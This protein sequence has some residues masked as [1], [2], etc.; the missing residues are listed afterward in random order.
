MITDAAEDIGEP[1]AWIDIIQAGGDDQGTHRGGAVATTIR[2]GEQP[3]LS[4]DC[5]APKCAFRCIV[6]QADSAIAEESTETLPSLQHVV[7]RF[8]DIGVAREFGTCRTHPVFELGDKRC[9]PSLA[10]GVALIGGLAVDLPLSRSP[11][12]WSTWTY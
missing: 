8:G 10:K 6:A 7:H 11:T 1:S 5:D 12:R 9:D 3:G 2:S 4:S